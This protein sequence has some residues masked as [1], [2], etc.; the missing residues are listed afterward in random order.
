MSSKMK[1]A[2]SF[3]TVAIASLTGLGLAHRKRRNKRLAHNLNVEKQIKPADFQ[4]INLT[5]ISH[6]RSICPELG[7]WLLSINLSDGGYG[8]YPLPGDNGWMR[9]HFGMTSVSI[10]IKDGRAVEIAVGE[11]DGLGMVYPINGS[12]WESLK[13]RSVFQQI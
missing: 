7:S 11:M 3:G 8:W 5:T 9:I 10:R 12:T 13:D 6:V 2:V 4:T 1:L